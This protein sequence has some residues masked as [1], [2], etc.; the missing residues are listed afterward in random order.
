MYHLIDVYLQQV[1]DGIQFA[2]DGKMPF[3]P[4]QIVQTAYRVIN[5]IGMYSLPLK[6]CIR[7]RAAD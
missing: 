3:A 6:E 2:Q 4:S 7:K 1:E 5:N